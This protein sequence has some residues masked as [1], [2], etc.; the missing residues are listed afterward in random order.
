MGNY[1]WLT[2][3]N[4]TTG[5]ELWRG[6]GTNCQEPWVGSTCNIAWT[7]VIDNGAGRPADNIGPPID[8]AGATL[9]VYGHDLYIGAAESGFYQATYAELLRVQNADTATSPEWQLLAGWPRKNFA[10]PSTRLPG[11]ENLDCTDPGNMGSN[12]PAAWTSGPSLLRRNWLDASELDDASSTPGS[13][14]LPSSGSGPGLG[15]NPA[16]KDPLNPGPNSYFWRMAAHDGDFFIGSLDL[17][18]SSYPGDANG[19]N[20]YKTS[21]GESFTTVA[22]TGL[23][24]ASA[25]GVRS[26]VSTPL[27]LFLGSAN[28]TSTL[29]NGGTD[30]FLGTTAPAGQAAPK[31]DAGANQFKFDTSHTGSL[32]FTLNAGNSTDSFGGA[33][34]TASPYEWFQGAVADNC[35]SLSPASAISTSA[36]PTVT[37]GSDTPS[38]DVNSQTYTLRVTNQTGK[39]GCAEVTATASYN[40]PPN[41]DPWYS[42]ANPMVLGVPATYPTSSRSQPNVNLIDDDGAGSVGYDVT[43]VCTD[44]ESALVSCQFQSLA[45]PGV[46]LSNIH[47]TTTDVSCGGVTAC[48]ISAHLS[49]PDWTTLPNTGNGGNALRPGVQVL[50]VDNLGYQATQQWQSLGQPIIDNPGQNDKPVCRNAD[51][52]M[53]VGLD[54]QV[55][56]DPTKVVPPICVDPDGDPMTYT[57]ISA[58]PFP[59]YGSLS[60][61]STT[62]TYTPSDPSTPKVDYFTFRATDPGGLNTGNTPSRDPIVRV[63]LTQDTGKPSLAVGFPASGVSYSATSFAD[64]CSTPGLGDVCGT[65]SD[66]LSGVQSVQVAIRDAGGKFW[67]GSGFVDSAG[68]PL[69][70]TASLGPADSW[71]F[72]FTPP[73]DASYTLL[74]KSVDRVG[75]ASGVV[76]TP[77][78]LQTDNGPP[79]VAVTFPSD[80]AAYWSWAFN[81]GCGTSTGDICGTAS[82]AGTG[83]STV[84]V[85][86]QQASDGAWWNGSAFVAGGPIWLPASGTTSWSY[87]FSPTAGTYLVQARAT[88]GADNLANSTVATFTRRRF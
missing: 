51:I 59:R 57:P 12:P 67:N 74:A 61:G 62:L 68:T 69:W 73:A 16:Y 40:L 78:G 37:V 49:V 82:D 20:L 54:S 18:G 81:A 29:P 52:A 33:G 83:V 4:R 85:S 79:T 35:T 47:D 10:D 25:Y 60:S 34:L 2:T 48:Q 39:V 22:T 36:T 32:S 8:N 3:I 38:P 42:G 30:V 87:S 41:V 6:D 77:F 17:T 66:A 56:F 27:G 46:T 65:A 28:G 72:P 55:T 75:N 64:G 5:F 71:S 63:T 19:F 76:E 14:C 58:G 45:S 50:A 80:G 84:E 53:I 13:D 23:G 1:L 44:P 43:A 9:G 88:D 70:Q 15:L 26:L 7:K 21:D 31:A 86:I 11:L 24:N